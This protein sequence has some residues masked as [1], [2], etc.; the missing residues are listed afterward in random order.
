MSLPADHL[1]SAVRA[2]V[3]EVLGEE[4]ADVDPQVRRSQERRFG[5]YQ[6][7]VA[8]A[9]ARQVGRNPRQLGNDVVN[10]LGDGGGAFAAV[11]VAGPGFINVTFSDEAIR[12]GI[13]QVAHDARLGVPSDWSGERIVVDYSGPNVAK[14]MHVGHLRSTI[15][16][17]ALA[18]MHEH[19]GRE[20]IRQ[21]HV[22]DWGTPF[23]MLIEHL[24]DVGE[25][26]GA[27]AL[28]MGDLTGFYQRARQKFDD[29]AEFARR[30]RFRVI[31]LQ[32]GEESSV[33]LWRL[34]YDASRRYFTTVYERLDVRLS[35][36]DLAPESSYNDL[37]PGVV[38]E[39]DA[40]GLLSLSDGAWCAFPPGFRSRDGS[41]MALIV[42]KA[43]GGFGYQATDLAAIRHRAR[44]LGADRILYVVGA[45]QAQHLEM[46]FAV[47]REAGWLD[48]T[49]VEH[50]A[51]GSVLGED[52]RMLR[53]RAGE[54]AKLID[55][56]DEATSRAGAV[57]ESKNPALDPP[58][59]DALAEQVGIGAVKYHDL[60]N[61]RIKDY[62]FAWDRMLTLDGNTAPYLQ[63]AC[64]RIHSIFRK[65]GRPPVPGCVPA[66][67]SE[68]AERDLALASFDFGNAV[69]AA[70]TTNQP[71]RL[72]VY[73]FELAQGF[74]RFYESCPVLTAATPE[75]V[76]T[77]LTLCATTSDIIETGLSLLGIR[78]PHTM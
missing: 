63:Y 8:M 26:A 51:F 67:A 62:T 11:D 17:D 30:S 74:S 16:G 72:C 2:A 35:D 10:A 53:T 69:T 75:Q 54:S 27:R 15:I 78:T 47:A 48:R 43:D 57:V 4:F 58:S 29:D 73:L 68:P 38:E 71:H 9:L 14:E 76:E 23:G 18:R 36:D 20:V 41:P 77:R 7:N 46:V 22:G 21:N 3:A 40:K 60:S 13:E 39:L 55:L 31:A 1:G 5:D 6:A 49:L 44:T 50:V 28:T 34:L 24:L 61:D 70:A 45:P 33:R 19:L 59:K 25:D 12:I 52:G 42:K 32:G 64:A 65:A 66:T 37:L 56:L